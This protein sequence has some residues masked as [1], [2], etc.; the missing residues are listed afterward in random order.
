MTVVMEKIE[1]FYFGEGED[2]GEAMF[3]AFANKH[4]HYFKGHDAG[5]EKA[6][7]KLE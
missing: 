2:S 3:K 7:H 5:D 4:A 6:E 1:E